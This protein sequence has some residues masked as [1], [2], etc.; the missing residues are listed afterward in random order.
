MTPYRVEMEL[1]WFKRWSIY[2][3][4]AIALRDGDSDQ[5]Y[6]YDQCYHLTQRLAALIKKRFSL[7]HGDRV[8]VL[9]TNHIEYV[10]LFFALQRIGVTMVPLNH[11]LSAN[12]LNY[13][14]QDSRSQVLVVEEQFKSLIDNIDEAMQ[15]KHIWS[16]DNPVDSVKTVL[17]QSFP[18][19]ECVD[20]CA[21]PE[22]IA[23]ILYTSGTTGFP[24]GAMI[25]HRMIFWNSIN[26]TM[27]LNLSQFDRTIN[28]APFFHTG[29]WNVL[30]LPLLHRGAEVI[31]IPKFDADKVLTLIDRFAVSLFFGVPTTMDMMSRSPYY[32]D[33]HFESVRYAIVGG[34]PMSIKGIET[35]QKRGVPIRQGYGLTEFGPNV[36]SLSEQ[37]ALRKKGS[38]GHP[39]F[40]VDVRVVSA[41]GENCA[42]GEV[43]ELWLKGPMCMS[44][45]WQRPAETQEV[46]HD[47]WLSTGDLVRQD[48]E[49]FFFVAGRKK[50]MYISG[51][52]NV[53]PVEV[54]RV[55][56]SLPE[57]E[58]VA[59]V[60]VPDAK[61]GESGRAYVV[62]K[63]GTQLKEDSVVSYC[64]ENLAK[65]KVPREV[66]FISE[67]P[68]GDSG[69]VQKRE[70]VQC[71]P[72]ELQ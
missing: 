40:Y 23:M 47:G 39:N 70:L 69:K 20:F 54:E 66:I 62:L 36:F 71:Q 28:F 68:K 4:T 53:Y 59:I 11:R 7:R 55:I 67:L 56:E 14:L 64:R 57:V 43:G 30:T 5:T 58:E 35:W 42:L 45:Y 27:R 33:T 25:S 16:F 8:A 19:N 21:E 65:F 9:A 29:G 49:G 22:D 1:D 6:T 72:Q 44:G 61:W 52:E 26:T 2:S 13:I 50:E 32:S 10:L 51:G 17:S 15:P 48:S 3:P 63:A 24:K 12:E 60:G 31:F 41:T 34:E 46:M 18:V 37:D 38:I